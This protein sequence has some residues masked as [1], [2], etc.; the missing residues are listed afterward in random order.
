MSFRPSIP[1]LARQKLVYQTTRPGPKL[2]KHLK[3]RVIVAERNEAAYQLKVDEAKAAGE[4]IPPFKEIVKLDPREV[5]WYK[6]TRSER[7]NLPVYTDFR[8]D[9]GVT[10]MIRRIKVSLPFVRIWWVE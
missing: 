4:A 1:L 3:N 5:G 10:T 6:V 9:G 8:A 2:P 7:G